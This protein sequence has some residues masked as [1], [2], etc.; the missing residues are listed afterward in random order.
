M[1]RQVR[2]VNAET[3]EFVQL[4]LQGEG[5]YAWSGGGRHA[6]VS[7][8]VGKKVWDKSSG[9]NRNDRDVFGFFVFNSPRGGGPVRKTYA[10]IA[11]RL[12]MRPVTVGRCVGR[13]AL[14]GLLIEAEKVGRVKFFRVNPRVAF[15]GPSEQQRSHVA[16]QKVP[17][18]KLPLE[19]VAS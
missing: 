3:G 16:S 11:E 9:L 17:H 13:L 2:A 19:E 12:D 8:G 4:E 14:G 15:D 18:P 10:E 7:K 6:N 5:S 1:A